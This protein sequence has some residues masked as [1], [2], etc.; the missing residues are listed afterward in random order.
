MQLIKAIEILTLI[1]TPEFDGHTEDIIAARKLGILALKRCLKARSYGVP[2][3]ISKFPNED[4]Y[5]PLPH[6]FADGQ[7]LPEQRR[8]T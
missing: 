8:K 7:N 1:G 5:T 2:F 3:F 4:G 6:P